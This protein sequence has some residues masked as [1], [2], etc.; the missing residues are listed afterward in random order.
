MGKNKTQH[1]NMSREAKR[2][3]FTS[4]GEQKQ[5]NTSIGLLG[6]GVLV[7]L[8]LIAGVVF[9]L[10]RP[11]QGAIQPASRIISDAVDA[12]YTEET[13]D[14]GSDSQLV[15]AATLGHDPYPLVAAQDG[16]VKLP[17][18]TYDDRQAHHYT[19][20]HEG[21]SIEFFVLQSS[22]GVTR[23]AFNACDVCFLSKKGYTQDGDEVVCNNCGRRFPADQIN[24]VK[25]G[26]NPS[27]L[28]RTVEGDD[29]VIQ[30]E[31]IV[32]G[33]RYF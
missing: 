6:T 25:G 20:V 8:V 4:H 29:L 15:H 7:G 10:T 12:P 27:P 30:V 32:G 24:E 28:D 23:A 2:S 11:S 13:S 16:V 33:L 14:T 21:K 19:Y 17:V 9:F 5:S 3:Q 1:R 22:D 31:D 18:S 26:C